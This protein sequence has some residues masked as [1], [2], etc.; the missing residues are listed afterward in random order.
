MSAPAAPATPAAS[1]PPAATP[2]PA[3]ASAT[4]PPPKKV[5][6]ARK[7]GAKAEKA[8]KNRWPERRPAARLGPVPKLGNVPF[9]Q[10]ERL[11]FRI[12]MLGAHAGDAILGVGKRAVQDGKPVVPLAAWLRSSDFLQKFYPVDDKQYVLLDEKTF[13]PLRNDFYVREAGKTVN[14][15]TTFD[16]GGRKVDSLKLD[17]TGAGKTMRR[18]WYTEGEILEPLECLYAVRRMDL[19]PG[20]KFSFFS[21]DGRRERFVDVKVVGEE[22]VWTQLGWF[23]TMRLDITTRVSGGFIGKDEL[24]RE[25]RKGSAWI[26]LDPRRTPVKLTSPTKLGDAQAILVKRYVED[27]D[28][29]GQATAERAAAI[30]KAGK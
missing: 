15:H 20:M 30:A 22:K 28:L 27:A 18:T 24:D 14:Y 1:V 7:A 10:G 23:D 29:L 19:K 26:G 25:A 3:P 9:E 12:E 11:V 6:P 21:W 8:R 5:G 17:K 13:L 16:Q 2:A 4:R